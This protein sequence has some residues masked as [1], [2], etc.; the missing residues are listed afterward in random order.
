MRQLKDCLIDHISFDCHLSH[1]SMQKLSAEHVDSVKQLTVQLEEHKQRM[2]QSEREMITS[3]LSHSYDSDLST[4]LEGSSIALSF[5]RQSASPPANTR[6]QAEGSDLQSSQYVTHYNFLLSHMPT[7]PAAGHS[8]FVQGQQYGSMYTNSLVSSPL[9]PNSAH[10]YSPHLLPVPAPPPPAPATYYMMGHVKYPASYP[11]C[12]PMPQSHALPMQYNMMQYSL[13]QHWLHQQPYHAHQVQQHQQPLQ[14]QHYSAMVSGSTS[15]APNA[16]MYQDNRSLQQPYH[17]SPVWSFQSPPPPPPQQQ[18]QGAVMYSPTYATTS[19]GHVYA[20]SDFQHTSTSLPQY[21]T[22]LAP[23]APIV[24]NRHHHMQNDV[25]S[26]TVRI[27]PRARNTALS[28][29]RGS[30]TNASRK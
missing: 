28:F 29:F 9:P 26:D 22:P 27:D 24:T 7:Y 4:H 20:S 30:Q 2:L 25:S 16:Y 8:M 19:A 5:L 15:S 17:G 23:G 21:P 1:R 3:S 13:H 10:C 14:Q 11:K 6:G 12:Q 18:Q